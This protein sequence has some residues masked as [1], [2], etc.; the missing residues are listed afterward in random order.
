M[1]SESLGLG[2]IAT[3]LADKCN[4]ITCTHR[5]SDVFQINHIMGSCT[6]IYY[7]VC[8]SG[9]PSA[10]S[11]SWWQHGCLARRWGNES[12]RKITWR[13]HF[14][15]IDID[16]RLEFQLVLTVMVYRESGRILWQLAC[17]RWRAVWCWW[18]WW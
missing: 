9:R 18:S 15:V 17:R 3:S 2:H 14:F 8:W 10:L 1:L 16:V 6:H 13:F 5:C 7:Q 4:I 12:T 11:F